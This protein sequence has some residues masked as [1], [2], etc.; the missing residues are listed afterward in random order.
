MF[1]AE[2]STH[3]YIYITQFVKKKLKFLKP[4]LEQVFIQKWLE[5]IDLGAPNWTFGT[6]YKFGSNFFTTPT[7][8]P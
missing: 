7:E 4:D 3:I 1:L 6:K 8:E 5:I 2:Q